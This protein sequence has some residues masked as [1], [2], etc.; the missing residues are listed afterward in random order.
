VRR[1]AAA[2]DAAMALDEQLRLK[3]RRAAAAV[4]RH[5]L[6]FT[7]LAQNLKLAQQFDWKSLLES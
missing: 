5:N 7:G 4:L 3:V 2:E 6:K 1:Q